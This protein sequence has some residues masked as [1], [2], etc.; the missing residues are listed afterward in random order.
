MTRKLDLVADQIKTIGDKKLQDL[1]LK[2]IEAIKDEVN[3]P[4]RIKDIANE[5]E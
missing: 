1:L 2:L 3:T 5:G 4:L